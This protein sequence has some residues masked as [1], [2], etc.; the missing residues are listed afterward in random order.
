MAV[1]DKEG[2]KIFDW[3][4]GSVKFSL[5]GKK[6]GE[7]FQLMRSFKRG[8]S[9]VWVESRRIIKIFEVIP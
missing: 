4:S 3:K 9:L 5:E 8:K 7:N 2:M 6:N 1:R